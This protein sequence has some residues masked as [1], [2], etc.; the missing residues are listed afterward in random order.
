MM[1]TKNGIHQ[2]RIK[3]KTISVAGKLPKCSSFANSTK[4]VELFVH[5]VTQLDT[6]MWRRVNMSTLCVKKPVERLQK[7]ILIIFLFME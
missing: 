4:R 2:P 6:Y 3:P 1:L 5:I 7:R